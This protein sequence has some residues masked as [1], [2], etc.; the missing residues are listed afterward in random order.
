M[1][2]IYIFGT[3]PTKNYDLKQAVLKEVVMYD[4]EILYHPFSSTLHGDR[5]P[6]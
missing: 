3:Y 2:L 1:K 5:Q 6:A 4:H